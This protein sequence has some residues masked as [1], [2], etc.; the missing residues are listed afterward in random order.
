MTSDLHESSCSVNNAPAYEP[1]ECDC[2]YK[3]PNAETIKAMEEAD[4][5]GLPAFATV[6]ALMADLE[7]DEPGGGTGT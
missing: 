5:A 3:T 2:K 4:K 6:K 1:G 7:A